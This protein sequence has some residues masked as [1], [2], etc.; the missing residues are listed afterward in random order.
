MVKSGKG[1]LTSSSPAGVEEAQG[2]ICVASTSGR[3]ERPIHGGRQLTKIHRRGTVVRSCWPSNKKACSKY[4]RW[5]VIIAQFTR[6][7]SAH[8]FTTLHV[9]VCVSKVSLKNT[10]TAK[11]LSWESYADCYIQLENLVRVKFW[12]INKIWTEKT[13]VSLSEN[14]VGNDNLCSTVCASLRWIQ[15]D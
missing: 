11:E 7:H 8:C 15:H 1:Q 2:Y 10:Q 13:S 9:K 3:A 4:Q 6:W 12:T 5:V 14:I